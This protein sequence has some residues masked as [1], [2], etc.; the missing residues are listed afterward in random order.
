VIL[1]SIDA[2]PFD[3]ADARRLERLGVDCDPHLNFR[4]D[5]QSM[6]SEEFP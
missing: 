4:Q 1:I 6:L 3:S 2:E 5:S